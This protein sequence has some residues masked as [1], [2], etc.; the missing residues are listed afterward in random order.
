MLTKQKP[1]YRLLEVET[2]NEKSQ[3]L[4][5]LEFNNNFGENSFPTAHKEKV[6]CTM[7]LKTK[8][9]I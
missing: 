9:S 3:M 8:G 4:A 1:K 2:N 5:F 7:P 6:S